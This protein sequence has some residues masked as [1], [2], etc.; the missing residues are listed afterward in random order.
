MHPGS[1][2]RQTAGTVGQHSFKR[3]PSG[4]RHAGNPYHRAMPAF[5]DG[6][7]VQATLPDDQ[8]NAVRRAEFKAHAEP[9]A[10]VVFQ[11]R[12]HD[13]AWVRW[14]DGDDEGQLGLVPSAPLRPE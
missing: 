4:G 7:H 10:T 8:G 14:L 11:G 2:V 1:P 6:D 5:V 3:V 13:A 9:S 12:E